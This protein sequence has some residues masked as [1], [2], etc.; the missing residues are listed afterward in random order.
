MISIVQTIKGMRKSLYEPMTDAEGARDKARYTYTYVQVS[1]F[2]VDRPPAMSVRAKLLGL[3]LLNL[4]LLLVG[5]FFAIAQ[6][7]HMNSATRRLSSNS[8]PAVATIGEINRILIQYRLLQMTHVATADVT[9]MGRF[10]AQM[11]VLEQ[12]MN[13]QLA[14][15]NELVSNAKD[16][17]VIDEVQYKL[18]PSFVQRT[19]DVLVEVSRSDDNKRS[20]ALYGELEPS[21]S[22]LSK[23]I[24][25]LVTSTGS[26]A[27]A[28]SEEATN[29]YLT[30]QRII[31]GGTITAL[32]VSLGLAFQLTRKIAN[33]LKRL[34]HTTTAVAA[35]NLEQTVNIT[36]KDELGM[37]ARAFNHMLSTLRTSQAEVAEQ[38]RVVVARTQELEATLANLREANV[39]QEQLSATIRD[40]SS[41]VLPVLPGVLVMPLVGSIDS[42]R[43]TTLTQT[44]LTAIEQQRAHLVILDVTG[45]PMV[46]TQ[47]AQILLQTAAA[48]KLLG[49]ETILVGLRPEL[50]QTIVGL[51]VDLN[52][53]LIRSDLFS[54]VDYALRHHAQSK[55]IALKAA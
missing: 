40:L 17:E 1:V 10:E 27:T 28:M 53:L 48:V 33:N 45:V 8:V 14:K 13:Q 44:L 39:V 50:A 52:A 24:N 21:Y 11:R 49:A 35:G 55:K 32:L 16:Q 25:S 7:G 6:L 37:L 51:G 38:H 30:S 19:N 46:D 26:Q 43:V 4:I 12:R 34:T 3:S 42:G 41:P 9:L 54:A 20:L 18:W 31:V 15:Y 47:V 36:S 23:K 5:G 29:T 22:Q 2:I